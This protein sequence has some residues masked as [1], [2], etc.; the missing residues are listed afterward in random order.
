MSPCTGLWSSDWQ[1]GQPFEKQGRVGRA[2]AG[3]LHATPSC[4]SASHASQPVPS[5]A[6]PSIATGWG[7]STTWRLR[8]PS[9]SYWK[10]SR[11]LR[12]GARTNQRLSSGENPGGE[13]LFSGF[14][15]LQVLEGS[16][17]RVPPTLQ[18]STDARNVEAGPDGRRP[19]PSTRP[20]RSNFRRVCAA[21]ER[22][23]AQLR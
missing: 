4:G 6:S 15:R 5:R 19:E 23:S 2:P 9:I 13:S 11:K 12:C 17:L 10:A 16:V 14:S 21:A 3:Q 1:R 7:V 8:S 18:R 22:E 20:R